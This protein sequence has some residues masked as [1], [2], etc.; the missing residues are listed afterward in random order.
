MSSVRTAAARASEREFTFTPRDFDRVSK[1][2]HRKAGIVLNQSKEDM[3]YSR[4]ARRLR[5]VGL[6]EFKQYL[7]K[8]ESGAL[9]QEWEGFTNALTTNLTAFFREPHHFDMLKEHLATLAPK[10]RHLIWCSAASTGEE[11]YSLAMAA[12]EHYGT[13]NPPVAILATDIDTN[14]LDTAQRGVYAMDRVEKLE[15]A[16]LK[17]FFRRGSGA[18]AGFCKVVEPLQRLISWRPLNLLDERWG[19]KGPFDA[20]FCRNVMIYFDKPTQH[21][22]IE[23]FLP[24]MSRE[25]LLFAGHS[26]SFFHCADLIRSRGRTVYEP[27]HAAAAPPKRKTGAGA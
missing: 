4:L 15:P 18:N 17:Q 9:E 26:E 20:V 11:P 10:P 7:D 12:V 3:V 2:I 8:L 22:I 1:L 13:F 25:C 27:V 5:E 19:L 16:R 21:Q 23:K 14:V 24:L 6:S